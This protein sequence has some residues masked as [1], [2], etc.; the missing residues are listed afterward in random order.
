[1][2]LHLKSVSHSIKHWKNVSVIS[3]V[4]TTNN[5]AVWK[6]LWSL[7]NSFQIINNSLP[8]KKMLAYGGVA[9]DLL[10][11]LLKMCR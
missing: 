7:K 2:L 9:C 1:M 4:T 6:K 8:V 10:T 3:E 11:L 5:N